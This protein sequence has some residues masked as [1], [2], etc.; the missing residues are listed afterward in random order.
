MALTIAVSFAA[1]QVSANQ[2]MP[3]SA[4][5]PTSPDIMV[6]WLTTVLIFTRQKITISVAVTPMTIWITID[7]LIGTR[8]PSS[9]GKAGRNCSIIPSRTMTA[10]PARKMSVLRFA[11]GGNSR[12][13]STPVSTGLISPAATR[14]WYSGSSLRSLPTRIWTNEAARRPTMLAGMTTIRMSPIPKS[15]G[16][17]RP[18]RVAIDALTGLAV[19][20]NCDA[21]AATASRPFRTHAVEVRHGEDD[22]DEGVVDETGARAEGEEERDERRDDRDVGRVPLEYSSWRPRPDSRCPRP[23]ASSTRP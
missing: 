15:T 11:S 19:M 18:T 6:P 9:S 10:M 12:A 22:R 1:I 4:I 3:N 13:S 23:P 20:A 5:R 16:S 8:L 17:S 7:V 14:R 2:A 21:V